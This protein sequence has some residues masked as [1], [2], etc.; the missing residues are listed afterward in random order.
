M[1]TILVTPLSQV[2]AAIRRYKPSHMMTLLSPGHMIETPTGI[3]ADRHLKLGLNDVLATDLAEDPPNQSHVE[4][5]IAFGRGWDAKSPLLIHCW[6]GISRSM[7]AAYII[8]C[9][10]FGPFREKEIAKSLRARAPHAYPNP[11]LVEY[12]DNALGRNGRMMMGAE[13]IGRGIIVPEGEIV[14][15]PLSADE[16]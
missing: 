8:L 6:A 12:A 5:L 15:F 10:R 7:A 3:V 9:D 16:L 13:S 4:K 2:E 14:E 11:L 1:S